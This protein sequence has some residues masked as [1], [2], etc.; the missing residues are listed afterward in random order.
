MK[1][2]QSCSITKNDIVFQDAATATGNGNPFEVG[3]YKSL[4]IEITGSV[5]NTARTITFYGKCKS[6]NLILIPACKDSADTNYTIVTSTTN[7][8]ESW[9]FDITLWDYIVIDIT[10]ITGGSITVTGKAM[11]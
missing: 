4:R 9:I 6:G 10:S 1:P 3:A 8:G 7:K 5:S 2:V 11:S